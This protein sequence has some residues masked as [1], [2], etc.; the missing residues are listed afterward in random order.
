MEFAS[1]V[2]PATSATRSPQDARTS[3]PRGLALL[4]HDGGEPRAGYSVVDLGTLGT[5]TSSYA[6]GISAAGQV[7]G[8]S[9]YEGSGF[10]HA[11]LFVGGTTKDLGTFGG[12]TSYANSINNAGQVVG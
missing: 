1:N 10:Y 11:T 5:G 3:G 2:D 9:T 7:V 12:Q 4:G 8:A 6:D